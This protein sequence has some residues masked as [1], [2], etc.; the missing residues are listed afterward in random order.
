MDFD[1]ARTISNVDY[2][3]GLT[4]LIVIPYGL[5]RLLGHAPTTK[6]SVARL[7]AHRH[8]LA[9]DLLADVARGARSA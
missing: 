8:R 5:S 3:I 6:A 7:C 9:Q 4:A 1:A 2:T